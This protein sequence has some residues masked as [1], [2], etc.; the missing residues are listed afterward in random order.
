MA[1]MP[2]SNIATYTLFQVCVRGNNGQVI[3]LDEEDRFRYL[4]LVEKYR[5]R[6]QLECFAFC[7]MDT[8]AHWLF[9]APTIRAL[10]KAMHAI[11]VAYAVYFNKKHGRSGHL[12]QGRFASWVILDEK[13]LNATVEYIENNPVTAGLAPVREAYRWSSASGDTSIVT[14]SSVSA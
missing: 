14:L 4:T 7:L 8:H 2:R 1:R 3:F 10:S 5:K 11:N 12:F 6:H 13:H 9:E